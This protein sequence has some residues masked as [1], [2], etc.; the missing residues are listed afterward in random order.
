MIERLVNKVDPSEFLSNYT[1]NALIYLCDSGKEFA[2]CIS[3]IQEHNFSRENIDSSIHNMFKQVHL[4][5]KVYNTDFGAFKINGEL[6]PSIKF[7]LKEDLIH[8]WFLIG[9]PNDI[10][11]LA[12]N[13][14]YET[15]QN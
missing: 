8:D 1:Y 11:L 13:P 5:D 12:N 3:N 14:L 9:T 7:K 6:Y 2:D 4:E 15:E 10:I